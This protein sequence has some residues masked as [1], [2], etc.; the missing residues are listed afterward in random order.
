M[1]PRFGV[2]LESFVI[3]GYFVEAPEARQK[4]NKGLIA[5]PCKSQLGGTSCGDEESSVSRFWSE[6]VSVSA[7]A[8]RG[9]RDHL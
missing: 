9:R 4:R 1:K 2:Q 6:R 8:L 5:S 3:E 7:H